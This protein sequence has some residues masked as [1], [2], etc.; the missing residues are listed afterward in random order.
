MERRTKRKYFA[1][2]GWRTYFTY[3]RFGYVAP[4]RDIFAGLLVGDPHPL[5]G[6]HYVRIEGLMD[7]MGDCKKDV[8]TWQTEALQ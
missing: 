5:F 3:G 8:N 1:V 7:N 6:C 2:L 4:L